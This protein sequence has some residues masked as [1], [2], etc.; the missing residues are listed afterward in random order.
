[1]RN[2]YLF[3]IDNVLCMESCNIISIN[4]IIWYSDLEKQK[5]LLKL[6]NTDKRK[7]KKEIR[8]EILE[9]KQSVDYDT[10]IS[11][12][13]LEKTQIIDNLTLEDWNNPVYFFLTLSNNSDSV[14]KNLNI[15]FSN[16]KK[17]KLSCIECIYK[18]NNIIS[19][20][21]YTTDLKKIHLKNYIYFVGSNK[22]KEQIK[23]TNL[24]PLDFNSTKKHFYLLQSYNKL[25]QICKLIKDLKLK[26]NNINVPYNIMWALFDKSFEFEIYSIKTDM[27]IFDPLSIIYKYFIILESLVFYIPYTVLSVINLKFL[28]KY[29]YSK[30]FKE[31][32]FNYL[33][34]IQHD[35][36]ISKISIR[37][38][39]KTLKN[40]ISN[41]NF[42]GNCL[43]Y[44]NTNYPL[45]SNCGDN[46]YTLPNYGRR[47]IISNIDKDNRDFESQIYVCDLPN[48]YFSTLNSPFPVGE[49]KIEKMSE[50]LNISNINTN[51]LYDVLVESTSIYDLP[52]LPYKYKKIVFPLGFFRGTY[53]GEEL[54]LFLLNGGVVLEVYYVYVWNKWDYVYTNIYN[55]IIEIE[56]KQSSI[57]KID[58][59]WIFKVLKTTF[60]GS[61]GLVGGKVTSIVSNI[62]SNNILKAEDL[63]KES[64]G[65]K[66]NLFHASIIT[67]K[68]RCKILTICNILYQHNIKI[69]R[70]NVDSLEFFCS[71][72]DFLKLKINYPEYIDFWNKNE[73]WHYTLY[74][75]NARQIRQKTPFDEYIQT[76]PIIG[77][78]KITFNEIEFNMLYEKF[79]STLHNSTTI[80]QYIL[81]FNSYSNRIW[82][83]NRFETMSI[84]KN[85]RDKDINDIPSYIKKLNE[86]DKIIKKELKPDTEKDE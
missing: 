66:R 43:S 47:E 86:R 51:C 38:I 64:K 17:I 50:K 30:K 40:N 21:I 23:F 65:Q 9:L 53:W 3:D 69:L 62:E 82:I 29:I 80:N 6:I 57:D 72:I 24:I 55:K 58:N 5:D 22:L 7:K 59:K 32:N 68:I 8:K 36:D 1:M 81:K 76:S 11:Q 27:Q 28:Y 71:K 67:T 73:T 52:I 25:I 12:E 41:N 16:V 18:E 74:I 56:N 39:Q 34:E 83:N 44:L 26:I 49:P 10:D 46:F 60:Y 85:E 54:K 79:H 45:I 48:A 42:L 4:D 61:L 37:T 35:M 31:K 13:L 84:Y 14:I 19:I 33:E 75:N 63:E 15:F 2:I 78:N 77:P 70:I 20:Y